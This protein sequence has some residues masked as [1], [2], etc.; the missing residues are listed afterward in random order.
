MIIY[1]GEPRE[2]GQKVDNQSM[3]LGPKMSN[4]TSISFWHNY[5]FGL[6]LLR[7]GK[8]A[9]KLTSERKIGKAVERSEIFSGW[10]G[11]NNLEP[12]V[13]M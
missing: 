5:V 10:S 6:K 12:M 9:E 3:Y 7:F 2:F 13:P 1:C 8:M 4:G 11:F